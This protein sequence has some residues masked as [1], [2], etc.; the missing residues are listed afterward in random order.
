MATDE[1]VRE[2]QT[3][4]RSAEQVCVLVGINAASRETE[5]GKALTQSWMDWHHE[6]GGR[7]IPLSD[8]DVRNLAERRDRRVAE[9][10]A[11]IARD[12]PEIDAKRRGLAGETTPEEPK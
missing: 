7:T 9:T 11:A 4:L 6:Y 8:I 1:Y 12:Y 2:L 10:L 3:R 5:R